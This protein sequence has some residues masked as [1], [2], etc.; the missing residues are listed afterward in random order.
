MGNT[1]SSLSNEEYINQQRLIITAQQEQINRLASQQMNSQQ[2]NPQQMNSQQMNPQ[3]MNPQQMNPQQMNPQQQPTLQPHIPM[4]NQIPDFNQ[5]MFS[6]GGPKK[7]K[8]TQVDPYKVFGL[9]KNYDENSLK[10]K[11]IELAMKYHPDRNPDVDPKKFK[12]I[13]AS[14]K[15]LLTK[16]KDSETGREHNELKKDHT[17]YSENQTGDNLKNVNFK[18]GF[19]SELFNKIYDENRI[20]DVYDKGYGDWINENQVD[21]SDPENIFKDGFNDDKF[22]NEFSKKKK[23]NI[24]KNSDSIVKYDQ[25][26]FDISFKGK[27]SIVTLGKG[28]VK[29]FSG[30]SG[31]LLYRDYKDAYT[32]SCLIDIDS[33]DISE[34]AASIKETDRRRKHISYELSE[35]DMKKEALKKYKEEQQ[36]KERIE[37]LSTFEEE[38]F[39]S[40]DR[41]HQRMLGK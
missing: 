38:A 10:K 12:V 34:R 17:Q 6:G 20:S 28:E 18:K 5:E 25:P 1:D 15:A 22:H 2:M 16:L 14:Y 9:S 36:E 31:G 23:K 35:E 26:I 27:D 30:E 39:N 32:N 37:R 24:E 19:S 11:Y 33:V 29:D 7:K 13:S 41:I 21:D 40:Y 3:Q 4:A 8:K